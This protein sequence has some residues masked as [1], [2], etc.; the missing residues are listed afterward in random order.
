AREFRLG[1]G[2]VR[3]WGLKPSVTGLSI[4]GIGSNRVIAPTGSAGRRR[5]GSHGCAGGRHYAPIR[6]HG[7]TAYGGTAKKICRSAQSFYI[8]LRHVGV[9]HCQF[10]AAIMGRE[11]GD[12]VTA[13]AQRRREGI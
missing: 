6:Q 8:H 2:N 4:K 10:I 12:G 9:S 1:R 11:N 5:G 13:G 3:Q 7:G